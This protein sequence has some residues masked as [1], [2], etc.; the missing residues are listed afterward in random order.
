[1][2]DVSGNQLPQAGPNSVYKAHHSEEGS[3][4]M[5]QPSRAAKGGD[6]WTQWYFST[7]HWT[8]IEC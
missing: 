3:W 5:Y 6:S 1:M 4:G 7:P 8:G 2:K